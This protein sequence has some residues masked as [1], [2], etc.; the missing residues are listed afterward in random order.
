MKPIFM[1]L[2]IVVSMVLSSQACS[3]QLNNQNQRDFLAQSILNT[4]FTALV[5]HT[6]VTKLSSD[7]DEG[8][9]YVL[10]AKVLEPISGKKLEKISYKI[11]VE[12]GDTVI[13]NSEPVILSLCEKNGEY[14]WPGVG[15][16]MPASKELLKLA[17]QVSRK[18]LMS[19]SIGSESDCD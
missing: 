3:N 10:N 4:P 19:N 16:E 11:A 17:H 15:A 2:F 14:Y 9:V 12:F 18:K 6:K 5:S 1:K 8:D 7:P 13:L